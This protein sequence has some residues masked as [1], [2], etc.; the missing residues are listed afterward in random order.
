M[1]LPT[2]GRHAVTS[3]SS[4][5]KKL[6]KEMRDFTGADKSTAKALLEQFNW[7][8]QVRC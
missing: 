1:Q 5:Q 3:M 8:I 4:R 2:R 7:D 6:I